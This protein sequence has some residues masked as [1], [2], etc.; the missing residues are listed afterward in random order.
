MEV[1]VELRYNRVT[2][3]FCFA[4]VLLFG[5]AVKTIM[6]CPGISVCALEWA[7]GHGAWSVLSRTNLGRLKWLDCDLYQYDSDPP[8]AP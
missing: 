3:V 8:R 4:Y 1:V 7:H 6:L 5:F 2:P